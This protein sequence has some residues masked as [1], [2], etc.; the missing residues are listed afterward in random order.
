V[1]GTVAATPA[2]PVATPAGTGYPVGTLPTPFPSVTPGG[3]P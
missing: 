1:S 2:T 3:Y